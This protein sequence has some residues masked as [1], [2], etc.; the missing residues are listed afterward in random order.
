MTQWASFLR[1]V[2]DHRSVSDLRSHAR[3]TPQLGIYPGSIYTIDGDLL[4]V[5][6]GSEGKWLIVLGGRSRAFA[7]LVGA[8]VEIDGSLM[9]RC[10]LNVE[11]SH[12][13][14]D[15]FPFM[16][17]Q[18][19]GRQDTTIGMGDRLGLATPGHIRAIRGKPVHPVLAQ[20]STREL[21]LT[22]RT[23]DQVLA[24]VAWGVLQEGYEGGFGADAD[25]VKTVED[26][27]LA[28]HSGYSMITLDCSDHIRRLHPED[29]GEALR[30]YEQ[31][32]LSHRVGL[33]ERFLGR[34]FRVEGT[35][36]TFGA[37]DLRYCTAVYHDALDYAISV[38]RS[39]LE[40]TRG[41][42]DFEL[43]IDETESTTRPLD[44]VYISAILA[45][46]GVRCTSV[47]PRFCGEFQ[48]G[49]DYV[50]DPY[51]FEVELALHS[52]I[53]REFGH[54]LSIHS[55]SDKFAVYPAIGRQTRGHVHVKTSGTSWLEAVRVL[56]CAEPSFFRQMYCFA[57]AHMDEARRYYHVTVDPGR[58]PDLEGI[59]DNGLGPLLDEGSVRQMLHITYG[60]FLRDGDQ[61]AVEFSRRIRGN[62]HRLEE[63]YYRRLVEH[64][65][66]HLECLGIG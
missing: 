59:L 14:A 27:R 17:P 33:E 41:T 19:M 31:L 29:T 53:A 55:G 28:L 4:F 18:C 7:G 44:H 21:G 37:E 57:R 42:V 58:L 24:D 10:P 34:E 62:L 65:V 13:L 23:F 56:A 60:A 30:Y 36:F 6:R 46:A 52:A 51:R 8:R 48:K 45:D 1:E 16:R 64:F 39:W 11:N 63:V 5:A 49:I 25:H 26:I 9:K 40:P 12:I 15:Q 3:D 32:D 43:S 20:Q 61:E 38:Y 22:G 54:K 47:A 50:G 35:R 2:D 66:R